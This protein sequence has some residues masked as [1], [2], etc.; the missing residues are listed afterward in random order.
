MAGLSPSS[1]TDTRIHRIAKKLWGDLPGSGNPREFTERR[2]RILLTV[3]ATQDALPYLP[4]RVYE[5][6]SEW[7]EKWPGATEWRADYGPLYLRIALV[8][9]PEV[10]Q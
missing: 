9:L 2:V 1:K 6:M 3:L 8:P 4:V 5:E 10:E 7:F